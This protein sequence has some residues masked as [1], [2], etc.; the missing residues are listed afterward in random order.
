[1]P[2]VAISQSVTNPI[3]QRYLT[4]INEIREKL[5][6]EKIYL[7]LDKPSYIMGDTVHFKSYL[8][9]ADYLIPSTQSGLLYVELA[10]TSN[11]VI[12]RIVIP[13]V[14]GI[15]WGDIA[16]NE[17]DIPDGSY[18]LRAYT[19]WMKNFGEDYAYKTNIY[20]SA[21]KGTV[22]IKANFKLDTL[23]EANK[24]QA[25]LQ[26]LNRNKTP[27]ILKNI[28]LKVR[29]GY[30]SLGR[31]NVLTGMDG[32]TRFDFSLADKAQLKN[33]NILVEQR[34]K[35][36]DTA[37]IGVPVIINRP[38][39]MDMQFMPEG[40][41]LVAGIPIKVGFKALNEDGKGANVNG[42][43]LNSRH[44]QV[45]VF[46]SSHNG[47]GAFEFTPEAGEKYYSK[48]ALTDGTTK[49]YPLPAVKL[50]GTV[51][52]IEPIGKDSLQLKINATANTPVAN[53]YLI[54][55]SRGVVCYAE[56]L[57]INSRGI[58]KTLSKSLFPAGIVH[59]ALLDVINRPIN[60]RLVY[61]HRDDNLKIS[62]APSRVNYGIRDSIALALQVNDKDGKPVQGTFSLAVTDDSQ[63]EKSSTT[64]NMI[65]HLLFTSD[66]KGEIEEPGYYFE[67]NTKERATE[68]DNLLLTQGWVGYSWDDIFN[69]ENIT[70]KYPA[71][72]EFTIKGKV[73]NAFKRPV[74]K[75]VVSLLRKHPT[76]AVDTIT[77]NDGLFA[78]KG[79]DYLPTDSAFFFIDVKNK[80]GNHNNLNVEINEF[81]PLA[82][83]AQRRQLP[84]YVNSDSI[85]L[86][87][88]SIK[89]RQ[90][91]TEANLKGEGLAL[92]EV[93]I[94]QTKLIKGSQNPRPESN[95]EILDEKDMNEAKTM[96]LWDLLDK[97]FHL[98][99]RIKRTTKIYILNYHFG[100]R[101]F[102][103]GMPAKPE[104]Y[105]NY[106]TAKDVRGIEI[107]Y[108]YSIAGLDTANVHVTTFSGQ[109]INYTYIPGT[110]VYKPVPFS[111][112]T[113]FYRPRYTA[114]N[115]SG[116]LG[117][118]MRSVIH[119][120]PNI[121]TDK[122]GKAMVSFFSADKLTDYTVVTEGTD[123]QGNIGSQQSK[124]KV[125]LK[126][127]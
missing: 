71:E 116:A 3:L 95:D 26:F 75:S 17:T 98:D 87:N 30:Q 89:L 127:P 45:A 77:D 12:K 53:Y 102:I 69:S 61:I 13:I 85:L 100:I 49:N 68:L 105:L 18:T 86:N 119:W 50:S 20:V 67:K 33:L 22:L 101:L 2:L 32:S 109:G 57:R 21:V 81:T 11:K 83:V 4:H 37:I 14:S 118:D 73:V 66:L 39:K 42:E 104:I 74:K 93:V 15:S 121:V 44:Q 103:D 70:P 64:S 27:L 7:Q 79:D 60:E 82:F 115:S 78:F 125:D 63:V 92:K 117:T 25:T 114:K 5:P 88:G 107:D 51:L 76:M 123:L 94:K 108:V 40:G 56:A 112:P 54:A 58:N 124:I 10:N 47:M 126:G 59:F 91:Q 122:D 110:Y 72:K 8:L 90:L 120:E 38:E 80:R 9:N 1:V 106:L 19:N 46:K 65:N 36:A 29:N 84:W 41:N 111:A 28:L 55:K 6:V 23:S 34:D 96:T 99:I 97:K 43:V 62:I 31:Y 35:D 113:E 52:K 24:V 16:L 48:V